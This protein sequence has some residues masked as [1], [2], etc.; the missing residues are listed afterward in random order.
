[1]IFH[2][3]WMLVVICLKTNRITQLE[4]KEKGEIFQG[5]EGCCWGKADS[6]QV[7]FL[8][9]LP[10]TWFFVVIS[11]MLHCLHLCLCPFLSLSSSLT[12]TQLP[13]QTEKKKSLGFEKLWHRNVG[14]YSQQ[15]LANSF[16]TGKSFRENTFLK[17]RKKWEGKFKSTVYLYHYLCILFFTFKNNFQRNF[18]LSDN[19]LHMYIPCII[20]TTRCVH[21]RLHE[22][23]HHLL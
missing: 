7:C 14:K 9:V 22:L 10:G 15:I 18:I 21:K 23:Q 1:M 17:S 16:C 19:I 12:H 2:F 11:L 6:S 8:C 5:E 13:L 3:R 4:W 20:F